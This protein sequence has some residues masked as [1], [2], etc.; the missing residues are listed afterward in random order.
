MKA[1]ACRRATPRTLTLGIVIFF[2]LSHVAAAQSRVATRDEAE[3]REILRELVNIKSVSG[4]LG[5]QRAAQAMSRRLLSAGFPAADVQLLGPKPELTAVVARYRGANKGLKPILLLAHLDVVTANRAD[6]PSDPFVFVEKDGWYYGRGVE[7][8]KAGVAAI[9]A[10]FVRWKRERWT[11]DRDLVAVLTADEETEGASMAWLLKTHRRLLD[12]E[13]ALN[14]DAGGG[15]LDKGRPI[16][17]SVQAA[18]KVFVNYTIEVTNPG[19]HSSVP[20]SDN[21]IYELGVALGK[22]SAYRFPAQLNE[23]TRAY[24]TQS[25]VAIDSTRAA[26]VRRLLVEPLDTAAANEV[27]AAS[28]SWNSLLRTT[29]VATRLSGGHADNA[30]PQR[31]SA[32]VNCRVLPDANLDSVRATL[33]R[34]VGTGAKVTT[35]WDAIAS[36]ASPL[37]A[38]LMAA[39]KQAA[40]E[41]FPGAVVVPEMSTGATDGLFTRN[42]GIPTYGILALFFEMGEPSRAHGQDERIGVKSFNDAVAFWQATVKSL[43][44]NKITP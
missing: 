26:M 28:P 24:F 35:A 14:A 21:A 27:S 31:A 30:L 38:D 4:T 20:R 40:A 3:A 23:V 13:Y 25:M 7:D 18:E 44:T 34:V 16:A 22:L 43:A 5:V 41:R 36:P 11:P 42:A 29:C 8:D 1:L 12:A 32:L 6:W 9:V 37:R 33:Q 19:G 10:N 39:V 15:A 2:L 17:L